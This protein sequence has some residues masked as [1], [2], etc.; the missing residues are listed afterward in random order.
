MSTMRLDAMDEKYASTRPAKHPRRKDGRKA[1]RAYLRTVR[2]VDD[3]K[4]AD[5]AV[6]ARDVIA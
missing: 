5:M 4:A 2:P 1:V 6:L 3:D